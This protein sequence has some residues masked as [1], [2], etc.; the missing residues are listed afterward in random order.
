MDRE[1]WRRIDEI[2][3]AA[4]D[5]AS[6]ER[7]RFLDDACAGEPELRAEV[8]SLIA[9]D[10]DSGGILDA[11]VPVS[12]GALEPGLTEQDGAGGDPILGESIGPYRLERELG[13]GGMGI[14]YLARRCDDAYR[15]QVAIKILNPT[16]ASASLSRRFR[17]ERQILA[18]LEHP[19][20]ARLYE[21]GTTRDGRP[22]LVMEHVDGAPIDDY[23]RRQNLSLRERLELFRKVCS[24]VHHAHQNLVV[25]R[26]VKPSN[27]LVTADGTPRLLDFGIAKLLDPGSFPVTLEATA[28]GLRP[29]TPNYASPEQIRGEAITTASDVYSLG[30]LL[31]ELLTGRLP[32]RL[33]GLAPRDVERVVTEEKPQPPSVAV[34]ADAPRLGRRLAGALDNVVLAALSKEPERRYGSVQ[35]LSEDLRRHLE[36][37]PVL[38]RPATLGY[39]LTSFI[40]RHKLAVT[41][42]GLFV[43]LVLAFAVAMAWQANQVAHQRDRAEN[44]RARAEQERERAEQVSGFL[45]ELFENADPWQTGAETVTARQILDRGA[46]KIDRELGDQ[47]EVRASLLSAIGGVYGELGLYEEAAPLIETAL[48][49][50]QERLGPEHAD[51]ALSLRNLA[52]LYGKQGKL[53]EAE[54]LLLQSLTIY[55]QLLSP[56]D[57]A[58]AE[59]LR[60]LAGLYRLQGRYADAEGACHQ[61][62]AIVRQTLGPEHPEVAVLLRILSGARAQQ[63]DADGGQRLLEEALA[64]DEKAYGT[65]HPATGSDLYNLAYMRFVRGEYAAAEPFLRRALESWEAVLPPDHPWITNALISLALAAKEQGRPAEAEPALRRALAAYEKALGVEHHRTANC[66]HEL[67]D[68]LLRQGRL[69]EAEPFLKGALAAREKALGSG[70]PVIAESLRSLARLH[71]DRGELTQ[72]ERLYRRALVIWESHP[73]NN[74]TRGIPEAYAALLR[75][76]GRAREAAEVEARAAAATHAAESTG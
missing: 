25:H 2:L 27:I 23:C 12:P 37:L 11:P 39:Q 68:A 6:Q 45:V 28:T 54:E 8:E 49:L 50:R 40:R 69:S 5:H 44:E 52:W 61:A 7:A 65:M 42:A 71:T 63:G 20:I 58:V 1:R 47:P 14:V 16:L 62:L 36:G 43:A 59:T 67:G 70:H 15:R 76:L 9:A 31:Y 41:V 66:R 74:E 17:S 24:A 4:L 38:A 30:V 73:Q 18:N 53:T 21:G 22:Y 48:E 3:D 35:Q 56:Q 60:G 75:T 10:R 72:A 13:R 55:R 34:A 57:P 33:K 32:H 64:I 46:E 26:D 19:Y 51:V 29:M